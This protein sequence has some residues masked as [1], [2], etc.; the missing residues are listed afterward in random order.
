MNTLM[1]VVLVLVVF[2]YFG[3]KYCPSA[4]K[5]NKEMLLGVAGGLVLCSF[6]GMRLEGLRTEADALGVA[7][8]GAGVSHA[9]RRMRTEVARYDVKHGECSEC[10]DDQ[11]QEGRSS[12]N[13]PCHCTAKDR[14]SGGPGCDNDPFP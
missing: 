3:G 1:M 10:E 7:G 11:M 14:F 4:L 13:C 8:G 5:K 12:E 6:F 9:I 2:C